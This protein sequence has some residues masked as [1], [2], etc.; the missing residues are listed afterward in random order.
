[1]IFLSRYWEILRL[2]QSNVN[3]VPSLY[4]NIYEVNEII[5][6]FIRD[7]VNEKIH[8]TFLKLY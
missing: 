7:K 2:T 1:M 4:S 6:R 8:L 5:F 3:T